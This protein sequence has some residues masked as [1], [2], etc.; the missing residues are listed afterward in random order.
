MLVLATDHRDAYEARYDGDAAAISAAKALVVDGALAAAE[1]RPKARAQG[2]LAVLVDEQYAAATVEPLRAAGLGVAMPVER[3]GGDEFEFAFGEQFDRHLT[4]LP[5]DVAKALVRWSPGDPPARKARQAERLLRLQET[6]DALAVPLMFELIVPE[7]AGA[8]ADRAQLTIAAMADV[9]A[10]GI[11]ADVWKLEPQAGAD[12]Y[13][14][15]REAAEGVPCIVLGAGG[16]LPAVAA[17]VRTAMAEGW[18]GFAVGRSIWGPALDAYAAG[19]DRASCV[20]QVAD[21]YTLLIDAA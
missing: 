1:R 13:A 15:V 11:R 10:H 20:E 4:E 2:A 9:C 19:A 16:E 21:A 5:P 6:L 18:A 8:E 14:Q 12:A 7:A 3:G 17:H